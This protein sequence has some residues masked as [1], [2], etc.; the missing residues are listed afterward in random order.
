M[1]SVDKLGR[2]IPFDLEYVTANIKSGTGG[3][4][5]V[6]KNVVK[7]RSKTLNATKNANHFMNG[8]INVQPN[9]G[10]PLTKIHVMLIRKFN[11]LIVV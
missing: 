2:P 3:E 9:G 5:K 11:N 8:T 10:G 7:L 4:I 6:L 1:N